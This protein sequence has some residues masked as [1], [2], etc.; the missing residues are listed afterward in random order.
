MPWVRAVLGSGRLRGLG[1]FQVLDGR[2][3]PVHRAPD[4]RGDAGEEPYVGHLGQH[5]GDDLLAQ[6][7]RRGPVYSSTARNAS[8]C[9]ATTTATSLISSSARSSVRFRRAVEPCSSLGRR[10]CQ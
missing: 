6:L 10:A 1:R 8:R 3:S 7:L 5:P 2:D 9:R 4:E